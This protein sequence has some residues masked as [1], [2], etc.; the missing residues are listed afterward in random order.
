MSGFNPHSE[1]TLFRIMEVCDA[2]QQK[3]LQGLDYIAT[4]GSE[5]F[6]IVVQVV[7]TLVT[8]GAPADWG[9]DTKKGRTKDI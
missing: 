6:D 5:A 3:S 4:E 8:N 2:S 9:K 7:D 1:R